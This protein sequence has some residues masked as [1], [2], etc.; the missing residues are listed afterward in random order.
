M[1]QPNTEDAEDEERLLNHLHFCLRR[2]SGVSTHLA[3]LVGPG[4]PLPDGLR[5]DVDELAEWAIGAK[6]DVEKLLRLSSAG[7]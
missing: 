7:G 6:S 1:N 4:S 3:Q 5:R 2:M